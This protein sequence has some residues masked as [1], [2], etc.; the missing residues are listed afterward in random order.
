M[1]RFVVLDALK[2]VYHMLRFDVLGAAK[3]IYH[4]L[5]FVV[6]AMICISFGNI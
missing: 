6:L 2:Q 3:Q 1:L 5:R 4:M